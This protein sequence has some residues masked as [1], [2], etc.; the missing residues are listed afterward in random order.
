MLTG[1]Q[2]EELYHLRFS[3]SFPYADCRRIASQEQPQDDLVS[4]LQIY[5]STI[6]G[7]SST[8]SRL[9]QQPPSVLKKIREALGFDFFETY[10]SLNPYSKM[11][12]PRLCPKLYEQMS[13]AEQLRRGLL[14][15]INS[16]GLD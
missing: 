12:S 11:I 15:L 8:A 2:L 3:E 7:L 1:A 14:D 13:V 16:F 5:F 6:A 10:P 9:R 4:A